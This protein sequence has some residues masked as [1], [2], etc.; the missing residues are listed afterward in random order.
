MSLIRKAVLGIALNGLA[1]YGITYFLAEVTYKGGFMFFVVG[2][3][4]MGILN[5][6]IKPILRVL[7]VPLVFLT[8][9]LFL[10]VI[11]V[12]MLWLTKEIIDILHIGD[13]FFEIQGLTTYLIAGFL[14]G[15]INWLE[16]LFIH[17]K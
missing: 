3:F 13:V 5:T 16:H 8:A 17:N 14:F 10:I 2:G 4:V 15:I 1:L 11:N 7:A 6:L 9:G 12:V